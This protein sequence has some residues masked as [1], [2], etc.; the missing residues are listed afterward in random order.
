MKL[1]KVEAASCDYDEY[2]SF[3]VWAN[4]GQQAVA[5]AVAL[6]QKE[7]GYASN[8]K[9]GATATEILKPKKPGV[10]LGSFNAG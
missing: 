2:D 10:V 7:T 4:D 9:E 6:A 5:L 3:V 1:F 8:F